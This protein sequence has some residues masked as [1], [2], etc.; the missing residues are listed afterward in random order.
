MH[1]QDINKDVLTS[2]TTIEGLAWCDMKYRTE[3]PSL[4][5]FLM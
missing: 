2:W 4:D 3:S 1:I 5:A